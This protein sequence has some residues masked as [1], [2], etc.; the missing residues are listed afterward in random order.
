MSIFKDNTITTNLFED[1][2][3]GYHLKNNGINCTHLQ[4]YSDIKNNINNISIHNTIKSE[5]SKKEEPDIIKKEESEISKNEEPA[6][7]KKYCLKFI[8]K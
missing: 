5:I 7:I 3:I 8:K 6:I 2:T 4:L 1:N